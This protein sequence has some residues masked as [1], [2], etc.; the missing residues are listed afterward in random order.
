MINEQSCLLW[1]HQILPG[2][3]KIFSLLYSYKIDKIPKHLSYTLWFTAQIFLSL[4][5]LLG[6]LEHLDMVW[7]FEHTQKEHSHLFFSVSIAYNE[8]GVDIIIIVKTGLEG[9]GYM[10]YWSGLGYHCK[11]SNVTSLLFIQ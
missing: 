11:F 10:K 8:I 2:S 7:L 4:A 6:C 5:R 3:V 9:K 1:T